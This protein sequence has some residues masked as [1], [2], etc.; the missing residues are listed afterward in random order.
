MQGCRLAVACSED[1][2]IPGR[3]GRFMPEERSGLRNSRSTLGFQNQRDTRFARSNT[4]G[5]KND[6]RFYIN[7]TARNGSGGTGLERHSRD[8]RR[9]ADKVRI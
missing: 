3:S 8:R 2:G 4:Q 6:G 1:P 7:P 9:S 5:K